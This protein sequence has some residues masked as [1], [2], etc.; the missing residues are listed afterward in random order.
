MF[1]IGDLVL[2]KGRKDEMLKRLDCNPRLLPAGIVIDT[3]CQD[4]DYHARVRV[5]WVG[6]VNQAVAKS[7]AI[8]DSRM[9]TWVNPENFIL[10]DSFSDI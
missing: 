2:Y 7:L 8:N 6:N 4:S 3:M 9:T 5:M 10:A 1:S